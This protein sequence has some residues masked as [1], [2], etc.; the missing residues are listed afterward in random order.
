MLDRPHR[1]EMKVLALTPDGPL[2]LQLLA[3][4]IE[5]GL[6]LV[7][8][9]SLDPG[10]KRLK[11]MAWSLVIVDSSL[12]DNIVDVVERIAST[13]QRVVLLARSASVELTLD[14]LQRGA[15]DMLP[16]PIDAA[17]LRDVISR[18]KATDDAMGT[19]GRRSGAISADAGVSNG[20]RSPPNGVASDDVAAPADKSCASVTL[21]GESPKMVAAFKTAARVADSTATVLIQGQSG[22]G[23]ELLARFLHE[24][25]RRREGPFVAVNCAAIPEHLLE[26][27]LFGH[28]KGAFTGAVARRTGRFERANG[29]T[30]F[31]D[32]VGDMS[33]PLQAKILRAL[34]ER[35]VERLGGDKPVPV[36]VR[37]VA[38]TN[39]T[40]EEEVAAGRFRED[41]YYR[42]AVVVLTLP[43]LRERGDDIRL[44]AEHCIAKGA[45]DRGWYVEAIAN[46]TLDF[47]RNYPWPGNVRQLCN[48]ME[49]SLLMADGPVLLPQHLPPEIRNHPSEAFLRG[50]ERRLGRDRRER[51]DRR[52]D[53]TALPPLE[54]LERDHIRRA[55]ALTGGQLG[56]AADLLGIHRNTLRRKLRD[57]GLSGEIAPEHGKGDSASIQTEALP[58]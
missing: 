32:E 47:L 40:L 10:R 6:E 13:G 37:L 28:E 39:R 35:E 19:T 18:C 12:D 31:L 36:D 25:S 54:A 51:H 14:A 33:L 21:V 45:N 52:S 11:E 23:K 41:L 53:G 15:W 56:R 57:W 17:E 43:P 58:S 29:G 20:R 8:E 1:V 38:A 16:F 50:A 7:I 5:A 24:Q 42:L 22:T 4:Q 3:S 44:L 48:V 27:E 46:E 9:P 30:L 34:Q 49:R 26:S 55:L 2:L